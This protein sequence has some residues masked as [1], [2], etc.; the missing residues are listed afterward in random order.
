MA[1]ANGGA[2][3]AAAGALQAVAQPAD[4]NSRKEMVQNLLDHA[5]AAG[6]ASETVAKLVQAA[7]LD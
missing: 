6:R 5:A 7:L 2:L 3:D 1:S 4:A